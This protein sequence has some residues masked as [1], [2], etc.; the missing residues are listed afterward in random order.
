VVCLVA[1]LLF[2]QRVED[3]E[4]VMRCLTDLLVIE[5]VSFESV[6]VWVPL[7]TRVAAFCLT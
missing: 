6:G 5:K 3:D 2:L 4:R 1:S 7:L